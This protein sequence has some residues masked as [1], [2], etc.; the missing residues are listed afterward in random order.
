MVA[1]VPS[2]YRPTPKT[3]NDQ[4]MTAWV[5]L[6]SEGFGKWAAEAVLPPPRF[7][8]ESAG[9][10]LY[11]ALAREARTRRELTDLPAVASDY[12]DGRHLPTD[13][14]VEELVAL[15]LI[16]EI[17]YPCDR[18]GGQQ[19]TWHL[20]PYACAVFARAYYGAGG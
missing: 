7:P 9:L 5:M 4:C 3:L 10:K 16:E 8:I 17:V 12:M 19:V 11:L 1:R 2:P 20:T 18:S 13:A 14:A 15:H 6:G